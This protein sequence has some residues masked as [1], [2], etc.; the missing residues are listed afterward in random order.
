MGSTLHGHVSMMKFPFSAVL[1][2]CQ[3][4]DIKSMRTN[5]LNHFS[6]SRYHGDN[7]G[8]YK[9]HARKFIYDEFIRNGLETQYQ[10]FTDPNYPHVSATQSYTQVER[11]RFCTH[12][13][14]K[15][16]VYFLALSLRLCTRS[17]VMVYA[18][19]RNR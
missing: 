11:Q 14:M 5:I 19:G 4:A 18:I 13:C 8:V 7:N 12:Q 15:F 17:I 16:P 6:Q 9:L 2:L 1:V 10:F 3:S